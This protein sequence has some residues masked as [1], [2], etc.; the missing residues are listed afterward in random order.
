MNIRY[1]GHNMFRAVPRIAGVFFQPNSLFHGQ[2]HYLFSFSIISW[3]KSILFLLSGG[4][5]RPA[6]AEHCMLEWN[7][8]GNFNFIEQ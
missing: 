3:S 7:M 6:G 8:G 5:G 1:V 2:K 4:R